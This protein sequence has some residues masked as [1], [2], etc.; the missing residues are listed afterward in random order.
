M[1]LCCVVNAFAREIWLK[2]YIKE[3]SFKLNGENF[4]TLPLLYVLNVNINKKKWKYL[5]ALKVYH[6]AYNNIKFSV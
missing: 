4:I 6:I 3:I 1:A 2:M 5:Y